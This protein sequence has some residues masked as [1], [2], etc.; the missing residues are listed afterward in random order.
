MLHVQK[1]QLFSFLLGNFY[2]YIFISARGPKDFLTVFFFLKK[3]QYRRYTTAVS[4]SALVSAMRR[5]ESAPSASASGSVSKFT[6]A[7]F[8][9]LKSP[10]IEPK[11]HGA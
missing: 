8:H 11:I 9:F 5:E 6:P 7:H 3:I 2:I 10:K 1:H 4:D